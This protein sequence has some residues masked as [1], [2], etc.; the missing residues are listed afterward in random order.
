VGSCL[1]LTLYDGPRFNTVSRG[2]ITISSG[3]P[4]STSQCITNFK[5]GNN[6]DMNDQIRSLKLE[7]IC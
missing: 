5:D 6:N 3:N 2:P 7:R 1:R 4:V